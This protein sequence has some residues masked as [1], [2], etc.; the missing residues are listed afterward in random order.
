MRTIMAAALIAGGSYC[1]AAW[2]GWHGPAITVW[3]GAGVGLLALWA[4]MRAQ[5][6]DGWLLAMIMACG[7]VGDVLLEAI[8]LKTGA[9]AF[10][11]G[12]VLAITLYRRH[13]RA[14]LN[15]SD[16]ALSLLIA[17]AT[18]GA[19]WAMT[20]NAAVTLY[21]AGLGIMAATAWASAFAWYRV[22][23]G[24]MM[25]VASDLLIFARSGLLAGSFV[26]TLLV[27][28]LYFAGQALIA[29]GVVAKLARD[30]CRPISTA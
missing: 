14:A 4:A 9:V 25:F 28:P 12:H 24:A 20:G 22:G 18:I 11:I 30:D 3:K 17:P 10:L 6:L 5:T 27:W 21:A 15:N 29:T 13:R 16:A 26:P 1:L 19:A 23:P 2:L 8:G 7:A